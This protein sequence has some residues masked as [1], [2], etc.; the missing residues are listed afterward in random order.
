MP[1]RTPP[2]RRD[3]IT[4]HVWEYLKRTFRQDPRGMK[5]KELN[6]LLNERQRHIER[7]QKTGKPW[8]DIKS[9]KQAEKE[10]ISMLRLGL[11][12]DKK[13]TE[14]GRPRER[15]KYGAWSRRVGAFS[16]MKRIPEKDFVGYDIAK[17]KKVAYTDRVTTSSFTVRGRKAVAIYSKGR[18]G[19]IGVRYL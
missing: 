15:G 11:W 6:R 8:M 3:R 4:M 10:K 9:R 7:V 14:T 18:R 16:R 17:E 13:V 5:K 1:Y 19:I 12:E 2:R